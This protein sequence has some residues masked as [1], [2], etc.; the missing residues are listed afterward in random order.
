MSKALNV[1]LLGLFAA[2]FFML[3]DELDK[4]KTTVEILNN[5]AA[6]VEQIEKKLAALNIRFEEEKMDN[7]KFK[8]G[9]TKFMINTIKRNNDVE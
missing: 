2:A 9:T 8:A 3:K 6:K 4:V 7:D 1:I 5:V